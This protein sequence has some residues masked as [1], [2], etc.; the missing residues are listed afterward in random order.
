MDE[1]STR[2]SPTHPLIGRNIP[3]HPTTQ[4][5]QDEVRP[6]IEA[7]SN[8]VWMRKALEVRIDRE[9]FRLENE[10]GASTVVVSCREPAHPTRREHDGSTKALALA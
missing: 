9:E 10:V 5:E 6:H 2:A 7:A 3:T 4:E 1:E 8:F